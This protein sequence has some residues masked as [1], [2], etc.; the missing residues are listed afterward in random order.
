MTLAQFKDAVHIVKQIHHK[1]NLS[2][3]LFP[4]IN[5]I[6]QHDSSTYSLKNIHR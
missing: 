3:E 2:S 6:Q 5:Y 4:N 1:K